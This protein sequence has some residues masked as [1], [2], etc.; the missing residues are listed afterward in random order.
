MDD[1]L[2]GQMSI[3]DWFNV[4][5][6]TIDFSSPDPEA[7][8]YET[9]AAE[10]MKMQLVNFEPETAGPIEYGTRSCEACAWRSK[11]YGCKWA[12][13]HR[14]PGR[15]AP[16]FKYPNCDGYGHFM[17]CQY[18]VPAMCASCR[19]GNCFHYETKP[20]YLEYQKRTGRP[21][22]LSFRDP[23][24]EPNIYCTHPEG[25]LNRRTAYKDIEWQGFGACHW[26]RQHE[27]D[28]CD[29][30]EPDHGDYIDYWKHFPEWKDK[31]Y[32]EV[33]KKWEHSEQEL[34]DSSSDQS[35]DS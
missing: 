15:E 34:S 14:R 7:K 28:T 27:W 8:V 23:V 31:K 35:A 30:W 29:R 18:K 9:P 26:D 32:W 6:A 2:K 25:S 19:W 20:E 11:E 3:D 22:K 4:P 1:Q 13:Y 16:V 12:E 5:E 24:E 10:E 17:P 33:K 21:H